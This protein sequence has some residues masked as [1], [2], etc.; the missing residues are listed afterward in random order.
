MLTTEERYRNTVVDPLM[1]ISWYGRATPTG[2]EMNTNTSNILCKKSLCSISEV[3]LPKRL[4]E[5]TLNEDILRHSLSMFPVGA[6]FCAASGATPN[7]GRS[8]RACRHP[9]RAGDFPRTL[10]CCIEMLLSPVREAHLDPTSYKQDLREGQPGPAQASLCNSHPGG[11]TGD[12]QFMSLPSSTCCNTFP[13]S[14]WSHLD[15]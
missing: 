7:S 2:V 15:V 5:K 3:F 6:G 12:G 4:L 13:Y 14:V 10:R 8:A 11:G 9:W 1:N